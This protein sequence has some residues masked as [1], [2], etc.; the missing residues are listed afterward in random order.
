MQIKPHVKPAEARAAI[1]KVDEWIA[2]VA[3][4]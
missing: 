4:S 2:Q 1:A 3:A